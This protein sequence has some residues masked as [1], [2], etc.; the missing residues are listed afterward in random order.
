M[1]SRFFLSYIMRDEIS[2][3]K[4]SLGGNSIGTCVQVPKSLVESFWVHGGL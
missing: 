1:A 2:K 4:C 3:G